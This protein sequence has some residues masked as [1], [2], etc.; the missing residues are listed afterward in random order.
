VNEIKLDDAY[1]QACQVIGETVMSQ[2][3]TAQEL[4]RVEAQRDELTA[5]VESARED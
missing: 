1:A 5:K 3:F 4:A 2:R